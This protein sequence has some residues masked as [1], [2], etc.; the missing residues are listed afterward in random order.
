MLDPQDE[1]RPIVSTRLSFRVVTA[2]TLVLSALTLTALG[3]SA[4][5]AASSS[6]RSPAW[7]RQAPIR[8]TAPVGG[9]VTE[10]EL[11]GA[12]NPSEPYAAASQAVELRAH[13][14]TPLA[15]SLRTAV[16]PVTGN[17]SLSLGDLF[18]PGR[19][20]VPLKF[21]ATYNSYFAS[22]S[23]RVG[24]GW[25]FNAGMSLTKAADGTVTISQENGSQVTFHRNSSLRYVAPPRVIASLREGSAQFVFT[26]GTRGTSCPRYS[27]SCVKFVFSDPV[28]YKPGI[29]RLLKVVS[30][31][32]ALTLVYTPTGQLTAV[33]DPA[34]RTLTFLYSK[35]D[36]VTTTTYKD[37]GLAAHMAYDAKGNL[38]HFTN[39][40]GDGY[41]F[42]YNANHLLT[43]IVDPR[44][45]ETEIV[46]DSA[47]HVQSITDPAGETDFSRAAGK[48]TVTGPAEPASTTYYTNRVVTR[49]DEGDPAAPLAT[50]LISYDPA[51]LG[52]T[53]VTDADGHTSHVT[54]DA[55]GHVTSFTDPLHHTSTYQFNAA[56]GIIT[57]TDPLGNVSQAAT[58]SAGRLVSIKE[59]TGHPALTQT[60]TFHYGSSAYPGD[61]TSVTDPEGNLWRFTYDKYGNQ[62]SVRDPLGHTS[63]TSYDRLG[64]PAVNTALNGNVAGKDPDDFSTTYTYD[65][66]GRMLSA[67]DPL[68]N[69]ESYSYDAAGNLVAVVA[70]GHQT[71][72]LYD[73]AGRLTAVYQPSHHAQGVL[74]YRSDGHVG[75]VCDDGNNCTEYTYDDLGRPKTVTDAL[76]N[77][78]SF[79]HSPAGGI[80]S[81]TDANGVTTSYTHDAAGQTTGV[82]YSDGITHPETFDYD[83]D[84]RLLVMTDTSGSST[85]TYDSL[86]RVKRE[87][88]GLSM[89]ADYAYDRLD[90]VTSMTLNSTP[91]AAYTYDDAGR[92]ASVRD[93]FGNTTGFSYDADSNLIRTLF[94]G[95]DVDRDGY[96][97]AGRLVHYS[98]SDSTS[99]PASIDI[100][101]K[102][103]LLGQITSATQTGTGQPSQSYSYDADGQLG[104]VNTSSLIWSPRSNLVQNAAGDTFTYDAAN[105]LVSEDQKDVTPD[106]NWQFGYDDNGSRTSAFTLD[107]TRS[108]DFVWDAAGN[109]T[110]FT[111]G[112]TSETNTYDGLGRQVTSSAGGTSHR[113]VWDSRSQVWNSFRGVWGTGPSDVAIL[114]AI[115]QDA[116][117][118]RTALRGRAVV[119]GNA[120]AKT[121]TVQ[122]GIALSSS[123]RLLADGNTTFIYGPEGLPVEQIDGSGEALFYHHDQL[124][125][126]RA[127]TDANAHTVEIVAYDEFGN[128]AYHSGSVN[129]PFGFGGSYTD[130]VSHLVL[131]GHDY[132][133]PPTGQFIARG[134]LKAL[135]AGTTSRSG[136]PSRLSVELFFDTFEEQ[137][138]YAQNG[139]VVVHRVAPSTLSVELFFD[140]YE[141][142]MPLKG[143][144]SGTTHRGIT[145]SLNPNGLRGITDSLN[146]NG[147]RGITDSLNPNGVKQGRVLLGTSPYTLGGGDPINGTVLRSRSGAKLVFDDDK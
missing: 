141:K 73:A 1:E 136:N 112:S 92:M 40:G 41:R 143:G 21:D 123:H 48:T 100:A 12:S 116:R 75:E 129:V 127:V 111:D 54:Y 101:Y 109:L 124:G 121:Y 44:G 69:R 52:P 51:T 95:G 50:T 142:G 49:I 62:T 132:Y 138:R 104:S 139:G 2:V 102:R 110:S 8:A 133:D 94:P 93:R 55:L 28:S 99:D 46:Y 64:R 131:I 120:A 79:V 140:G 11:P 26:R 83:A 19:A 5:P 27:R 122:V 70:G 84:G 38:G 72:Y 67:T 89:E 126:T 147:L 114:G 22:V 137:A 97:N 15:G 68:G 14:S 45:A 130:P 33:K 13:G 107:G 96:D 66:E 135:V 16:N 60:T 98:L 63:T 36:K 6:L 3:A 32:G 117:L 9:P 53:A 59:D 144:I 58:D 43:G 10:A 47:G 128:Q 82:S 108:Q 85:F 105:R 86:G 125:S 29:R 17:L 113:Y 42:L 37:S 57:A 118:A 30:P 87:V 115:G 35:A 81:R 7:M 80:I 77:T 25:S 76:G 23:G 18:V 88:T 39:A 65:P 71:S 91:L 90:H 20:G 134:G 119:Q 24:N 103:N 146:P 61:V 78:S 31:D 74:V 4:S 106:V 34:G 56:S 145:D